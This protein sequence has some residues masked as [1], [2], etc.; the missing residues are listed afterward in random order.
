M[1][2]EQRQIEITNDVDNQA[3][4]QNP[5][6]QTFESYKNTKEQKEPTNAV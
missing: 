5:N 3:Y 6:S 2:T 4:K 1:N